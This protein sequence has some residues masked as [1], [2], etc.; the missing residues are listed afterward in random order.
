MQ[1]TEE[2]K[3]ERVFGG[4]LRWSRDAEVLGLLDLVVSQLRRRGFSVTLTVQPPQPGT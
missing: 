4:W 3:L 1:E 2:E